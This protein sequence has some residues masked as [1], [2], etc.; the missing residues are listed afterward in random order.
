MMNP[1]KHPVEKRWFERG[2]KQ[3]HD[4]RFKKPKLP[5]QSME[6]SSN[7]FTKRYVECFVQG[8]EQGRG[9]VS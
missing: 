1:P 6:K 8:W 7:A 3:G 9:E 5:Y 4:K 2:R